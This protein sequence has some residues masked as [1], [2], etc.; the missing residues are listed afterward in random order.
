MSFKRLMIFFIVLYST[1]FIYS[2]SFANKYKM[3]FIFINDINASMIWMPIPKYWDGH[4]V[5]N[6]NATNISPMPEEQYVDPNSGTKIAYWSDAQSHKTFCIAFDIF[7]SKIDHT[8]K[9]SEYK[10]KYNK[11]SL[12][13][14]KYTQT[15]PWI[16]TNNDLIINKSKSIVKNLIDPYQKAK[17]IFNWIIKQDWQQLTKND[18]EDA[19][20][21]LKTKRTACGGKAN[22]FVALCRASGIP[23]RSISGFHPFSDTF[24]ESGSLQAFFDLGSHTWAEFYLSDYGWVQCE[25]GHHDGFGKIN[26]ERIITSKGNNIK[27]GNG[28]NP[29]PNDHNHINSIRSHFHL[30]CTPWQHS[31]T[32][33]TK[34]ES[35]N[36]YIIPEVFMLLLDQ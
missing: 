28:Y 7:L 8:I 12:L 11:N 14:K 2:I 16:Q 27:L 33:N 25:P 17:S 24:P 29:E 4:G 15:T 1:L 10:I 5:S 6:V 34:L 23:A 32:L 18:Y 26:Q 22:L 3:E 31:I 19:L 13:Y 35:D 36:Q 21:V 9:I 30:P 20:S